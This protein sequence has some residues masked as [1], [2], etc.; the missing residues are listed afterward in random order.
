MFLGEYDKRSEK[1]INESR[2]KGK[3]FI[4]INYDIQDIVRKVI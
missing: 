1:A 2:N 4:W 3:E